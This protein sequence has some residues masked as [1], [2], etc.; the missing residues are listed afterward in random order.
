MPPSRP[1]QPRVT[2]ASSHRPNTLG[3]RSRELGIVLDRL[4]DA[5]GKGPVNPKRE[6]A[7]WPFRQQ[8]VELTLWHPGGSRVVLNV[9]CRNL[10]WGGAGLLHNGFVHTG[11]V[12]TLKL[13]KSDGTPTIVEGVVQRCAHRGGTMHELGI[14]F[15]GSVDVREY[16]SAA[17]ST[18]HVLERVATDTL[19]GRL[20]YVEDCDLDVQ[21]VRHFLRET[22]IRIKHAGTAEAALA[23]APLGWDLIMVDWRLGDAKG[24]D[25]VM[26]M[27][28][29]GVSVPVLIV[30]ADPVGLVKE[31][32]SRLSDVAMIVK[33]LS[34]QQL[35]RTVAERL[36][37]K[38]EKTEEAVD[39]SNPAVSLAEVTRS[40]GALVKKLDAS[41]AAS[42]ALGIT[43]AAMQIRGFAPVVGLADAGRL[44]DA[45][46]SKA[47]GP[48][49]LFLKA[50]SDLADSCRRSSR[51]A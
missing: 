36:M 49:D 17:S 30:T 23:E 39:I 35:L 48:T 12:C 45:V 29:M 24:T 4:D 20:L 18:M 50:A 21:I 42:D 26:Q 31:G 44:A 14:K 27:R 34:Q 13:H 28:E 11:S 8:T 7:R 22:A 25:V 1:P 3:L 43:D 40:L 51:A 19:E 15:N 38:P 6:F 41:I 32:L 9:A 46:V 33:P 10:A 47:A 2:V 16:V 37:F 5:E